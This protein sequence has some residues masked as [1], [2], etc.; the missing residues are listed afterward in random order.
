MYPQA[1]GG[2]AVM[3]TVRA[4]ERLAL[5]PHSSTELGEALGIDPRTARVMLQRLAA[6]GYVVQGR[7]NR[8]RYRPTLRLAAMGRQLLERAR[9][10][11]MAEWWVAELAATTGCTGHLW[12]PASD[13]VMCLLHGVEPEA[14]APSAVLDRERLSHRSCIYAHDA[15]AAAIVD[16]GLVV[17]AIGITGELTEAELAPVVRAARTLSGRLAAG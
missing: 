17:A 10:P 13:A 2:Y 12:I 16:G 4:L 6:E 3:N 1:T 14:T 5:T 9:L 8:R 15:A 11:R 7:G